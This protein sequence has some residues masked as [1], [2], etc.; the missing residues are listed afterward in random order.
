MVAGLSGAVI[1]AFSA[2]FVRL[3][4][5]SPVTAAVFRCAYALP[6]LALLA[7]REH[8]RGGRL[9]QGRW[10]FAS[11]AGVCFA[12]DLVLW[13]VSIGA[14]GAGLA[15]VIANMQ[16]VLVGPV[17]WAVLGERPHGRQL[18]AM[19]LSFLGVVLIS[20]VVG[21][22]AYGEDPALGAITGLGT[23]V[24]Y[25][26][27]LLLLRHATPD[28]SRPVGPLAVATGVAFLTTVAFGLLDR[29]LE[30]S[31]SWPAHGWLAL[32]AISCQVVAWLLIVRSLTSLPAVVTSVLLTVQPVGSL[33]LGVLLLGESPSAVQVGGCALVLAATLL[34]AT[35]GTSSP[36]VT[37]VAPGSPPV[38]E[39]QSQ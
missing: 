25:T 12:A 19:P 16:V 33:V 24:A 6:L 7:W 3:A 4:D 1:I 17:A 2:I 37:A 10:L 21:A 30:A 23:A 14:V 32:L 5:V 31:P 39:D 26:G 8:L 15:T 18:L 27:F 28:A 9:D 36:G 11:G 22:G 29:S 35:A 38:R 20:G 34:A 13:H